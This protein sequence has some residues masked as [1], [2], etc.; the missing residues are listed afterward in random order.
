M[1]TTPKPRCVGAFTIVA[2]SLRDGSSYGKRTRIGMCLFCMIDNANAW[3]LC[4]TFAHSMHLQKCKAQ[5]NC[6]GF[7]EKVFLAEPPGVKSSVHAFADVFP[8]QFIA[9]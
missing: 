6:A 3:L 2:D 1:Q 9:L 7:S 4:K 8:K 5:L